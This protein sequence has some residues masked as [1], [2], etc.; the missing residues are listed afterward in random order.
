MV[1]DPLLDADAMTERLVKRMRLLQSYPEW[2]TRIEAL[3]L[4]CAGQF[5]KKWQEEAAFKMEQIFI[6]SN[7]VFGDWHKT[8]EVKLY[9]YAGQELKS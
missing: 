3:A 2:N 8:P 6:Q 9:S 4:A 5:G 1:K 7:K